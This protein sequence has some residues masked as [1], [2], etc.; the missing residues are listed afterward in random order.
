MVALIHK[1]WEFVAGRVIPPS[2]GCD[3]S[4]FSPIHQIE[5]LISDMGIKQVESYD[6]SSWEAIALPS[7]Q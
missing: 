1:L 3:R 4:P 6:P 5:Q 2:A 7:S